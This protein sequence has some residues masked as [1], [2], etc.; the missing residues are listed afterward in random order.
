MMEIVRASPEVKVAAAEYH[1]LLGYPHDAVMSERAQELADWA[2]DWYSRHG[3]PWF[4]ARDAASL[5]VADGA[6][7]IEGVAFHTSRLR[8]TLQQADAH[9]V[10]LAAAGAG[11]EAEAESARLWR[12]EKPDEYFFLEIFA[13]AVVEKLVATAGAELCA[14]ADGKH[15]A[16]LPHHSPGYSPWDVAEQGRLLELIRRGG[17]ALPGVLEA[18]DSGAL[19]PKKSQL[20]VFGVTRH[21]DRVAHLADLVPCRQCSLANCSYRR[22][23][24]LRARPRP[25]QQPAPTET[26]A[27]YSIHLKALR[28]WARERLVVDT[29]ADGTVHARFRF[30][31]TTCTN[32]G[33][34]LAFDY[35]VDL[36]AQRDGYPIRGQSCTPAPGDAGHRFMCQYIADSTGVMEAIA[37]EKPLAGRPLAEALEWSRPQAA[38]GCYCD[39]A[40]RE[41][42]WGL[43]FETI[44]YALNH[45][46]D[47]GDKR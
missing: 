9:A 6:V 46:E 41:H 2:R 20:A 26:A 34:E 44:H 13:S 15:M 36:G 33:R 45:P 25:E 4:Y 10:F 31:G 18:L 38:A 19:R 17:T 27:A 37:R 22:V 29:H 40:S 32:L 5:N 16:V 28:R 14:W 23:P 3:Q 47:H 35:D 12:D 39:A 11:P 8:S 24:Y 1:R 43:V 21:L 7:E 30:D 42:K